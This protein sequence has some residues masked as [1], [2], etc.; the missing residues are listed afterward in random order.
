MLILLRVDGGCRRGRSDVAVLK[1]ANDLLRHL[2]QNLWVKLLL[3]HG[4][5]L[6]GGI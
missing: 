4:R 5:L 3:G 2:P 1:T 6:K